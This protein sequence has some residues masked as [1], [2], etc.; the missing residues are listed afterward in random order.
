MT[1]RPL[2]GIV[3]LVMGASRGIGAATAQALARQ[4]AHVALVARDAERLAALADEIARAGGAASVIAADLSAPDAPEAALA[5][6]LERCGRLDHLINNAATITPVA[7][8]VDVDPKDWTRGVSL[9]LGATFRA[10]RAALAHFERAGAGVIV[11]LSSGAAHRPVEGWS[12]YCAGKA[13]AAML[14][15]SIALEKSAAL[16][17]Y[18]LQPGAVDTDMLGEVRAA[19]L[20]EFARRPRETLISPD[21][22]A[23]LI[24]WLC[25][26]QPADLDGGELTIR[27]P[28]LRRRAGLPEG[29]Y[30]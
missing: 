29:D 11:H 3:S 2:A 25:R 20:S 26:E 13:A 23:A 15:R 10:C 4:G 24:A 17:V 5:A 21:L 9:T 7:R 27:D 22:P 30:T 8:L 16:R 12:A 28:A 14:M 18:A 19:G 6:A 1:A